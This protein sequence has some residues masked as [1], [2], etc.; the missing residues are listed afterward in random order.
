MMSD[1]ICSR[2]KHM[3]R[4]LITIL[5]LLIS[6]QTK[7]ADILVLGDSLS[8]GYGINVDKGWVQLMA[9]DLGEKHKVINA[10]I[11]GD[12]TAGGLYRLPDLLKVHQPD[13]VIIELGGND[14]LRGYPLTRMRANLKKMIQLSKKSGAKPLLLNIEIPPNYGA[15]YTKAFL[16]SYQ[17]ISKETNT[18]LA[19]FI[20]K[21]LIEDKGLMQQDGIHPTEKAQ[22]MLKGRVNSVLK[23]LL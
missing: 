3:M 22:P 19:E 14:G 7:A 6:F 10:S 16:H 20:D 21:A 13:I 12:T 18:P 11:S 4:S 1:Y 9:N 17:Q 5:I 2:M 8:A 23:R 15:R